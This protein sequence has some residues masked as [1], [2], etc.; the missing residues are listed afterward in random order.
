MNFEQLLN[1]VAPVFA[2]IGAG[3]FLRLM[4]WMKAEADP[5]LLNIGVNLL[6][7]ALIADTILGNSLLSR[8]K[9][10][11]LPPTLAFGIIA[12][13]MA[14]V[15][16]LLLPLRLPPDTLRAGVVCA[17]MQNYG[18][19]V[20]PLVESLYDRET[21][22][23]LFLHNLG[24]EL[25]MWSLAVSILS[26][27]KGGPFWK[28]LINLPVLSIAASGLLNLVNAQQWMPLFLRKSMHMLGLAA[29]PLALLLTGGTLI[30][31]FRQRS[32]GR[33][34]FAGLSVALLARLA[35]LPALIL[36]IARYLPMPVPLQRILVL[37]ASMPAAMLPAVLCRHYQSDSRFSLQI[38]LAT[39]AIGLL[40]IP[41][42]IRL[43][44]HWISPTP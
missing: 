24:V 5:S 23:V 36:L 39:T 34:Q 16:L 30:D 10:L 18:Y 4:G 25:A 19:L 11:W 38:I 32:E 15:L 17:G 21:L 26:H 8:P 28:H 13:S 20:I 37:Q 14:I 41:L 31:L 6:Y 43:G 9:D 29:I 22:G 12:L 40:T 42:W 7:P 3:V 1:A 35:L 44:L 2:I 33:S 27:G